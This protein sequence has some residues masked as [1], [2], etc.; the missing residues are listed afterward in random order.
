MG[1]RGWGA[2]GASLLVQIKSFGG[3]GCPGRLIQG[4]T[5]GRVEHVLQVFIDQVKVTVILKPMR[6]LLG[7]RKKERMTGRELALI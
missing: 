2:P 4:K 7:G 3:R 6:F 5:G 1:M